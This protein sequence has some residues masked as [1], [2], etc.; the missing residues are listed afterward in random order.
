VSWT[1]KKYKPGNPQKQMQNLSWAIGKILK[2]ILFSRV[3]PMAADAP[4]YKQEQSLKTQT[5]FVVGSQFY[6]EHFEGADYID[7]QHHQR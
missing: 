2:G 7:A 4:D 1:T 3:C 6:Q 5:V